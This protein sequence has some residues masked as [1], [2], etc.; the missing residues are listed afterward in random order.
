MAERL[1]RQTANL[2]RYARAG[3]NPVANVQF[4]E[5]PLGHHPGPAHCYAYFILLCILYA[6]YEIT[7]T[8]T[9]KTMLYFLSNSREEYGQRI[10]GVKFC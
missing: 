10:F 8:T 7:A 5:K 9:A 1:R 3:S 2:M 6:H 4:V